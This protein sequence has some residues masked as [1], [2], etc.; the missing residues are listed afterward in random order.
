MSFDNLTW[1]YW[2]DRGAISGQ[3]IFTSLDTMGLSTEQYL[4]LT[5]GQVRTQT[6]FLYSWM[7]DQVN[8]LTIANVYLESS[9]T[10]I[11]TDTWDSSVALLSPTCFLQFL[12]KISAS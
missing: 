10:K 7:S 12:K 11:K 8:S 2:T 4:I 1:A 6:N 5:S 9:M 3:F